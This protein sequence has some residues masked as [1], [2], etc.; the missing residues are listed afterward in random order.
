MATKRKT[1]MESELGQDAVELLMAD[2]QRVAKLFAEFNALKGDGS[3]EAKSA[4]V[5][6]ICQELIVHTGI[7]EEIFYPAVR[8][9]IEDDDLMD[10][11]LVEHAGAKDLIAQLQ[12]AAPDDDL[13]DAR[14]TVL[15]EQIEHHVDE[16]EGSMFPQAKASGIDLMSLGATLLRRKT[17]LLANSSTPLSIATK[18]NHDDVLGAG[19]VDA[20]GGKA[21]SEPRRASIPSKMGRP[22][23]TNA[24]PPK[25][26]ASKRAR[27]SA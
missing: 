1:A 26:N 14:V 11:A 17:E 22:R 12:A 24:K 27:Q 8:T 23:P 16:E 10:E 13:Y 3:D 2:H 4:L 25:K 5:A 9:A 6:R 20:F 18:V 19:P 7:E 15:G 21:T